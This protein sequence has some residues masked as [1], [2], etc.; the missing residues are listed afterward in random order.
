VTSVQRDPAQH[1]ILVTGMPRSGTTWVGRML[2]ASGQVGYINEPFNLA[3][4]P[5]TFRISVDHWYEYISAANEGQVL[6]QLLRALEFEYPLRRELRRCRNR[7]HLLHTLRSWRGFVRSRH[8]RPLVKEPHAVFSIP[9]FAE[10]LASDVV[11]TVRHPAAVVSSWKR[12]DW[13]FDFSNLL[14]QPTLM[15]DWLEPFRLEMQAALRPDKDLVHRVAFLWHVIYSVVDRQRERSP[16]VY[17]FRQEDLAR[18]PIGEYEKLF[19][20]MD[21]S[22]TEDTASAVR[23]SSSGD[24]PKETQVEHPHETRIDSRATIENWKQRLS[25][26][27]ISRIKR[28]TEETASLYYPSIEWE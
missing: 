17:V 9:W 11:V 23:A 1:P 28:L 6:P 13:S 20:A 16:R 4:S 12:L 3:V 14:E 19:D 2:T 26:E 27:E 15:R 24:N 18:D 7:T 5:G 8:R 22:F 21:L 25:A 10:R